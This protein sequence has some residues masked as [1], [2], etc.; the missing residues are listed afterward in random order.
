VEQTLA[1]GK[2]VRPYALSADYEIRG[3]SLA[4]DT[5]EQQLKE[6]RAFGDAWV[7]AKPDSGTGDRDWIAGQK[8][9]AVFVPRD[10]AGKPRPAISSVLATGDARALYRL[11]QAGDKKASIT[12]NKA[13]SIRIT[14]RGDPRLHQRGGR[15]RA[16]ERRGHP[17]AARPRACQA[18]F[19]QGG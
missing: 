18:R 2:K 8:V 12:Y 7:G 6:I 15:D 1:W 10:S 17:P 16:G 9:V 13:D 11:I 14:M 5:P 3:D 4:F 19:R